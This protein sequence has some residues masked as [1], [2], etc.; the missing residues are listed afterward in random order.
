[1]TTAT[2]RTRIAEE[3]VKNP[4]ADELITKAPP[5]VK[6]SR[7]GKV[8]IGDMQISDRAQGA[9]NINHA[10]ALLAKFDIDAI[11]LFVVSHRDGVFWLIDGQHRRWAAIEYGFDP[12]DRSNRFDCEIFEGLTE[13]EEAL[14]FLERNYRKTKTPYDKFKVSCTAGIREATEID[15]IVRANGLR[16]GQA[17]G[18]GI[19]CAVSALRGIYGLVGPYGLGKVLRIAHQSYG[20][21]G[22]EAPVITAISKVV[23]RYGGAFDEKTAI[24]QMQS[25]PG[26]LTGGLKQPAEKV[27]LASG[28]PAVDAIAA[29]VVTIYNKGQRTRSKVLPNWW[30]EAATS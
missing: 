3:L 26:G 11:G 5:A 8:A 27:R 22:L 1:M 23:K 13:A 20:D 4:R 30:R 2:L 12:A 6:R 29:Q 9:F 17:R 18:T 19:V 24:A 28:V 7:L 15:E 21:A 14:L 16:V 25:A 10:R